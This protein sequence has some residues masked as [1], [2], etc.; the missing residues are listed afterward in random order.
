MGPSVFPEIGNVPHR[1]PLNGGGAGEDDDVDDNDYDGDEDN[2]SYYNLLLI[3][4][5]KMVYC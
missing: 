4:T 3:N 2:D 1:Y 5:T